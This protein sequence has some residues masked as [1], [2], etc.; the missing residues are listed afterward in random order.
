MARTKRK[1]SLKKKMAA[2]T[3]AS[4]AAIMLVGGAFAWTDFSQF[5][6]NIFRGNATPDVLLHDDYEANVNKDVYVEN[7]GGQ[8]ALVR[9][10][11]REFF[12]VGNDILVG[13]FQ[14]DTQSWEV[15]KFV[16][17]PAASTGLCT[18]DCDFVC[19]DYFDW[20][21]TGAQKNYLR[22]TSEW[23]NIEYDDALIGTEGLNGQ[24]ID[25]T[26]D[27]SPVITM[28]QY[29]AAKGTVDDYDD[30][31]APGCWVLDT[32]GWAYWSKP[33]G[34]RVMDA[35]GKITAYGET[36]NLLLDNVL[37]KKTPND[38]YVYEIKV[39]L[40]ATN[41]SEAWELFDDATDNAKNLINSL[42][43]V[44]TII[45]DGKQ[46]FVGTTSDP[47]VVEILNDK[48]KSQSPKVYWYD[49]DRSIMLDGKTTGD[50][51]KT[52]VSKGLN[53]K[54]YV[55]NG[56]GT[57]TET[58]S[59][60]TVRPPA[61][62][63]P[64]SKD[65]EYVAPTTKPLASQFVFSIVEPGGN[66]LENSS[67]P[68]KLSFAP[69]ITYTGGIQ[70]LSSNNNVATVASNGL[71]NVKGISGESFTISVTLDDGTTATRPMTIRTAAQLQTSARQLASITADSVELYANETVNVNVTGIANDGTSNSIYNWLR[72]DY[73]IKTNGGTGSAVS[74]GGIFK[75]GTTAG[76]VVVTAT[77]VTTDGSVVAP[78]DFTIT[79][80][81][82]P[83]AD[84]NFYTASAQAGAWK[85]MDP[86]VVYRDGDGSQA[87]PYQISS[88]RQLK[89]LANDIRINGASSTYGK[90]YELTADLNFAGDTS[91][92][93]SLISTFNGVFDGKNHKIENLNISASS[94]AAVFWNV[95]Y[96]ELKNLNRVG[97]SSISS[98][99]NAAGLVGTLADNAKM[100]HCYNTATITA[101]GN[102]AGGLVVA[103]QTGAVV[104]N[105][106][107]TGLVTANEVAGG[108]AGNV[109]Y[110]G[111]TA[112]IKDCYNTGDV[113]ASRR[114][115]GIIGVVNTRVGGPQ[116]VVVLDN[117]QNFGKVV[118]THSTSN[119][120]GAII[121]FLQDVATPAYDVVTNATNVKT[122]PGKVF[123]NTSTAQPANSFIGYGATT[124]LGYVNRA[125]LSAGM[126][127]DS[128]ITVP[129]GFMK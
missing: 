121:G 38:N 81:S 97:G 107:N 90:Y 108:I 29:I 123:K 118:A 61:G 48:G 56:D 70:Y 13:G 22:G 79:V 23:G 74:A 100:I 82:T 116:Q 94:N 117:V 54:F 68:I 67:T 50:E 58:L 41:R 24:P 31:A 17:A 39:E 64:G 3:A 27:A 127:E 14:N 73:A 5:A 71:I 112:T 53:G 52:G 30:P 87:N 89:K 124:D 65:D 37:M 101:T 46:V 85:T 111:G 11:F 78:V 83:T 9:V 102:I 15:H 84:T 57:F 19:H 21:M 88:I 104:E 32:D 42:V 43:G 55:D 33:L 66:V 77:P 80:K 35:S 95:Q 7:T 105:C 119:Q 91:V 16:N 69:G 63:E 106:Y 113:T 129:S 110:A 4:L 26:L 72:T 20:Y 2:I 40:N 120:V 75:A 25:K 44:K 86:D 10:R 59:G 36:T 62:E 18:G 99:N 12:Q 122:L 8:E 115:G 114:I 98:A 1:M 96:G 92:D 126:T 45:V 109:S 49:P 93:A 51:V 128:G 28:A 125:T 34:G 47:N 103:I 6:R 60:V 76:T